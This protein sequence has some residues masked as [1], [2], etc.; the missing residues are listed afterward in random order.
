MN[1]SSPI[2]FIRS[3]LAV[4]ALLG[5]L[6]LPSTAKAFDVWDLLDAIAKPPVPGAPSPWP[7]ELPAPSEIKD[8]IGVA[9]KCA[10]QPPSDLGLIACVDEILNDPTLSS[11]FPP[12]KAEQIQTAFDIYLDVKSGDYIGL[13]KLLG[14]PLACAAAVII[15]GFDVCGALDAIIK[16][17]GAVVDLVKAFVE[18]LTDFA[19][20]VGSLVGGGSKSSGQNYDPASVQLAYFRTV[21]PAAAQLYRIAPDLLNWNQHL[22]KLRAS[23]LSTRKPDQT[24]I[25]GLIST[26]TNGD[27]DQ[28]IT[29][30]IGEIGNWW[31]NWYYPGSG[32]GP[33]G[34]D[35]LRKARSD[36]EK[37][38]ALG[39]AVA[40]YNAAD[41][42]TR[43]TLAS[44]A[45]AKCFAADLAGKALENWQFERGKVNPARIPNNELNRELSCAAMMN[46]W[47]ATQDAWAQKQK[48]LKS[49]SLKAGGESFDALICSTNA[50]LQSCKEAVSKLK[51]GLSTKSIKI[52]DNLCLAQP[53]VAGSDF[54]NTLKQFDPQ[55]RCALQPSGKVVNC[56]R[57]KS[58][59]KACQ[60]AVKAYKEDKSKPIIEDITCNLLRDAS[61][62]S[63]VTKTAAAGNE[64]LPS[65]KAAFD[66]EVKTAVNQYNSRQQDPRFKVDEAAFL[67]PLPDMK[68]QIQASDDPLVL[69]IVTDSWDTDE[70]ARKAIA[71]LKFSFG[72]F[73]APDEDDPENDGQ[74][75]PALS[76]GNISSKSDS[77]KMVDRVTDAINRMV[78]QSK[79]PSPGSPITQQGGARI[80]PSDFVSRNDPVGQLLARGD[81]SAR[82]SAAELSI[83][84]N[85]AVSRS[86][87]GAF[88]YRGASALETATLEKAQTAA[89][90]LGLVGFAISK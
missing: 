31:D 39:A 11:K 68:I 5:L 58:V 12:E 14:K 81:S 66:N 22:S 80:N 42:A 43:K 3:L 19:D 90:Q 13:V 15:V 79:E 57:D 7:S 50:G 28:A 25:E 83:L 45:Q 86:A 78:K 9:G 17:A 65:L 69:R 89:K 6:V 71:N 32:G 85:M 76:F 77:R 49:C 62:S 72:K 10:E 1:F 67:N 51:S 41:E 47:S 84:A 60:P 37:A 21:N 82:F 35:Q 20:W 16:V 75:L 53:V 23:A 64:I 52:D 30:Y 56:T 26:P 88:S 55:G 70:W 61:Y 48:A 46:Y 27:V 59:A 34:Q 87:T 36:Y 38:N 24:P 44:A 40:Q 63:L 54:I 2:P 33:N 8:I 18:G 4:V 73:G 29:A 74:N